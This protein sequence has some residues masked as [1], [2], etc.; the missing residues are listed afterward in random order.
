MPKLIFL[1]GAVGDPKFWRPLG[2]LLPCG[3]EKLYLGWP[4]LG[5]EAGHPSVRSI[6]DLILLVEAQMGSEP[7]D[8]LAQSLGGYIALKVALRNPGRVRRLVIAAASVGLDVATMGGTD[9]R[10]DYFRAF[11]QAAKWV[12]GP[13]DNLREKL[14]EIRQPVL[15]L[16]GTQDAISPVEVGEFLKVALPNSSLKIVRKG[17]HDFVNERPGEI[18]ADI[19]AHLG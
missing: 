6:D 3:W 4:G 19:C 14:P 12:A 5:N 8:I 7:A 11:P 16:W 13:T 2:D 10:P 15:L 18:V 9:W 17:D 1:P